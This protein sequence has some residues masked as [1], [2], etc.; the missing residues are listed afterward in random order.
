MK[1][2]SPPTPPFT[3]E[4]AKQHLRVDHDDD[5]E[6]IEVYMAAATSAID[7]PYGLLK[8]AVI[9]QTWEVAFDAFPTAEI[10]LPLMPLLTLDSVKYVDEAGDLQT[11]DPSAYEVDT[12]SDYGW[13]VPTDSWPTPMATINAVTVRWTAGSTVCP[14]DIR[15]AMLLMLGHLYQNREAVGGAAAHEVPLGVKA[16]CAGHRRYVLA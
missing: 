10:R 13:V 9:A 12:F 1:L 2:I 16:L 5:D 14:P 7:G 15:A 3:I 4:E 8:K 11:V 6:I